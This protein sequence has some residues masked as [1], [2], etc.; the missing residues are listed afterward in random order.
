MTEAVAK[1]DFIMYN[2]YMKK[3]IFSV[4]CKKDVEIR[5]KQETFFLPGRKGSHINK[6]FHLSPLI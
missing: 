6:P 2:T 5:K 4:G 3:I 1:L